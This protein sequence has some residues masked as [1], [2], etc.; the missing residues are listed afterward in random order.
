MTVSCDNTGSYWVS[1]LVEEEKHKLLPATG[2]EVGIDIGLKDLM[3]LSTGHKISRLD[4]QLAKAKR[5]I[6][7]AQRRLSKTAKGSKNREK[8]RIKLARAHRKHNRIKK[9]WH[10]NLS[11]WLVNNFD[12]IYMEDLNVSGML[13]NRKL[14]RAIHD[15]SWVHSLQSR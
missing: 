11:R 4:N 12:S 7:K 15:A 1:V 5:D 6:K 8:A 9:W 10:H 3:I 2:K 13:K 14:S